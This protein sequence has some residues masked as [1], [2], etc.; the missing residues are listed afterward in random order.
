MSNVVET[1]NFYLWFVELFTPGQWIFLW[2]ASWIIM[3]IVTG[4]KLEDSKLGFVTGM[5]LWPVIF[6]MGCVVTLFLTFMAY[7]LMSGV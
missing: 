1:P 4:V 5:F 2:I 7:L 6:V 3:W